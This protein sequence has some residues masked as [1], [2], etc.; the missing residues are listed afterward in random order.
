MRQID[1]TDLRRDIGY[2]PQDVGLF[3][4]TLR[5]NLTMGNPGISEDSLI[6]AI[7]F[8][9]LDKA[10]RNHPK[11]LDLEIA[12]GGGG[13]SVGQRQSVGLAR[14]YL[15]NPKIVLLDE[16][17]ASL[18]QNAEA[19]L[20]AKLE[21]WLRPRTTVLTTHRMG[22]LKLVD[23]IA[24][25]NNGTIAMHGPRDAVVKKLQTGQETENVDANTAS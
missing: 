10:I 6:E 21:K 8:S 3:K 18:D 5:E 25:L 4:G 2:L 19:E 1:P 22:I 20:I 16:P 11:G 9:G 24:V 12:D 14:L 15:Q 7:T 23:K 13:L 17:T